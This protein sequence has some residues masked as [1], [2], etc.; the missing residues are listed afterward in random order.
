MTL[1]AVYGR[2]ADIGTEV[3]LSPGRENL[4]VTLHL[5][6]ELGTLSEP[7]L[8]VCTREQCPLPQ[9]RC[10]GGNEIMR[11]KE[12][13]KGPE[14]SCG[15]LPFSYLQS[16]VTAMTETALCLTPTTSRQPGEVQ[17]YYPHFWM[18]KPRLYWRRSFSQGGGAQIQS[19]CHK[20]SFGS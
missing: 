13:D 16:T 7:H 12:P 14:V 18:E 8:H 2:L 20:L 19:P 15:F 9:R 4:G 5:L 11:H 1:G 10:E 6:F 17:N 3:L